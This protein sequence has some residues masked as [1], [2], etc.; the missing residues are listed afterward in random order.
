MILRVPEFLNLPVNLHG[1]SSVGIVT[2]FQILESDAYFLL[3]HT[4]VLLVFVFCWLFFMHHQHHPAQMAESGLSEVQ[5]G[6]FS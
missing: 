4:L 2:G 5:Q 1:M 3:A 6:V